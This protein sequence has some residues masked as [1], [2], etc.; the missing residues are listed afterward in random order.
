MIIRR[1][2]TLLIFGCA[3]TSQ[4]T[5]YAPPEEQTVFSPNG[6]FYVVI[7]PQTRVHQVYSV[8]KEV[9]LWEFKRD[10]WHEDYFV[11][12]DGQ[13]VYYV[14]W[15][16]VAVSELS[17]PAIIT[18]LADGHKTSLTY[19]QIC[20]P[21]KYRKDEIGPIGDSWRIWREA[22][23]EDQGNLVINVSGAKP[24]ILSLNGVFDSLMF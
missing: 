8:A 22:I 1:L 2:I 20:T 4:A 21:R 24:V 13:I 19:E 11:S 23:K 15:P 10:V 16:Y 18:Y 6:K 7:D 5:S 14:A 12:N 3:L 17:N 9:P